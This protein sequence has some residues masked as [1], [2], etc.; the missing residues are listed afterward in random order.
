[1]YRTFP[2]WYFI[3]GHFAFYAVQYQPREEII[4]TKRAG[5]RRD[6]QDT[7]NIRVQPLPSQAPRQIP[8]SDTRPTIDHTT[9]NHPHRQKG[10]E[11]QAGL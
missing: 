10:T 3:L 4:P 5:Q 6:V 1:M 2:H 11:L 8:G 9:H 7:S